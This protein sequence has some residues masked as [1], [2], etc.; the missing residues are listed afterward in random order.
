MAV[1]P[2]PDGRLQLWAVDGAG[3]VFT[4][5][6]AD[7]DPNADWVPWQDFSAEAGP[8]NVAARQVV[9]GRLSDLRL[10]IWV[11][12]VLANVFSSWKTTTDPN[13]TWSAWA[14]FLAEP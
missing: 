11:V 9:V 2:L 8:L 13:A 1:A 10:E 4:T 5:W 3:G 12:D 6:K 7:P 14:N